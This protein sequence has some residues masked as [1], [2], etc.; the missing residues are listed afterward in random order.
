[1]NNKKLTKTVMMLK[2]T[3]LVSKVFMKNST[4]YRLSLNKHNES[5]KRSTN[6]NCHKLLLS[7]VSRLRLDVRWSLLHVILGDHKGQCDE[8]ISVYCFVR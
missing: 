3:T 2:T 1:M 6:I 4:R 8:F 5:H 7:L